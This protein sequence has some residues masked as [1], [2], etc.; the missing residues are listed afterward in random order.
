M[1]AFTAWL[2]STSV[3][4]IGSI[5]LLLMVIA[6]LAANRLRVHHD[7]LRSKRDKTPTGID[8]HEGYITSAVLGL[9]A[10]LMG[11]TFALAVDRFE[12]RRELVITEANAIGTAYL[13]TQLLPEPHRARISALLRTYTDQRVALAEAKPAVARRM[14]AANDRLITDLWTATVAA[15]PS[16]DEF[17]FSGGYL[18]SI[19]AVIDLD[20]A[21]KSSRQAKV[22]GEVFAVLFVYIIVTS[23]SLGYTVTGVRGLATAG[24]L[25]VLI[26]M[27]LML[28]IDIVRPAS[29]AIHESQQPMQRLQASMANTPPATYDRWSA[30]PGAATP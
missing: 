18:D 22:P 6:A 16:I 28:T 5:V 25:L 21:R 9:L 13:R 27:S 17:D 14:V 15:F 29:G 20:E 11:F 7:L 23:G 19:N 8:G 30:K 1:A 3:T 12:T 2:E 4:A 24:V 10:L 26:L